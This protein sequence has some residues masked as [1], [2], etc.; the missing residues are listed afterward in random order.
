MSKIN[1][2]FRSLSLSSN[3]FC[4]TIL[5]LNTLDRMFPKRL[6]N[7]RAHEVG[8][9]TSAVTEGIVIRIANVLGFHFI[10][11]MYKPFRK[12]TESSSRCNHAIVT[13]A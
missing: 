3:I 8:H 5:H 1:D 12:E 10:R 4:A 13:T 11:Q 7:H 2:T 6:T 9:A